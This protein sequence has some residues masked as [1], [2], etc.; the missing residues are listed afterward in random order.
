MT[1]QFH[2]APAWL[3]VVSG[4]ATHCGIPHSEV[5]HQMLLD[6]RDRY[7]INGY[8]DGATATN[9]HDGAHTP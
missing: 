9:C 6:A 3:C 2:D 1:K 5:K 8:P 4:L 7:I